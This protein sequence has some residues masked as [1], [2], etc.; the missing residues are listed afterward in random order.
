MLLD[1]DIRKT[2]RAGTRE[3]RLDVKLKS[4]A[5][6]IVVLGPSGAGKTLLLQ[7]IAGLSRPDEGYIRLQDRE[8]FDARRGVHLPA[9]LRQVGYV[10]Q[11][12]AL[13]PHLNLRQNVGFARHKGWFNPGRRQSDT[14]VDRWLTLFGLDAMGHQYP[15]ELS[16]GQRQRAALARTL[17]VE[18]R[19]L[20]LD[21]PFAALDAELRVGLRR[22]LDQLQRKLRV[23]MVLIT[24]DPEDAAVLGDEIVRIRDGQIERQ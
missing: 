23:P 10:F 8:L 11:D 3:F 14:T 17:I 5:E 13:F 7:A 9:R 16:G 12:Y 22:E 6:R 24:H 1:L 20:L 4:K 19:A 21:E 18:P 15:S 2:L